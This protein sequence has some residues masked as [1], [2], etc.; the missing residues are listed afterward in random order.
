METFASDD[1]LA[2]F[3]LKPLKDF[4]VA[5]A[6]LTSVR[7]QDREGSYVSCICPRYSVWGGCFARCLLG[8][9]PPAQYPVGLVSVSPAPGLPQGPCLAPCPAVPQGCS[10]LLVSVIHAQPSRN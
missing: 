2:G 1:D 6:R 3:N 4:K 9:S 7:S 8:P 5:T 10:G